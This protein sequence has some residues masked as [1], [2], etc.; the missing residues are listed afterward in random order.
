MS[1]KK[2]SFLVH[3][4]QDLV[5]DLASLARKILTR[6]AYFL[7][8]GCYSGPSPIETVSLAKSANET[9]SD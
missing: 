6:F 8:D 5:Q 2:A 9:Q 3:N 4:L 1:C 7:Q